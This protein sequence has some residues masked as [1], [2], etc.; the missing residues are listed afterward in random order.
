MNREDIISIL[1][2]TDE[3]E[4]E[5]V[6]KKAEDAREKH[7]KNNI[8]IYGF[9]YFSTYCK[10]HC[11]FCYFRNKNEISR[12]RKGYE[13]IVDIS[14]RLAESGVNL[15]DL[16]MGEDSFFID[17]NFE[18]IFKAI[19]TIKKEA[20]VKV[21]FSPGLAS[22][23][24][25]DK[26]AVHGV[27]FYAL[28]QETHNKE[29]FKKLRAG[30]DYD[31]RMDAKLY[32]KGKGINIEE[33]IL[34]GVGESLEDIADSLLEMK[35][36]GAKQMRVMSFIPHIGTP[37][38]STPTP[39]RSLE[40]KIIALMRLLCPDSLIPA[41]L[42]V[43][44]IEGLTVRIKAG[45]NVVTSIIP[46]KSGLSGVAQTGEELERTGRTVAEV[47]LILNGLGL[48]PASNEL[49]KSFL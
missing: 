7:F 35:R 44:G 1:K 28:Y 25:I 14:L 27:D 48:K 26:M 41:S 22:L 20:D 40:L 31:Q 3:N 15:V 11:N 4:L 43:D 13:E 29:L 21:M 32:A 39:E 42:D 37:M 49:Y 18:T 36:I 45:A 6:F 17:E 23:E 2:I 5:K 19:D 30:Q 38:E 46:P 47:T 24:L 12:Y 33:G 34:A 8:F 10:N 16:T 9:V